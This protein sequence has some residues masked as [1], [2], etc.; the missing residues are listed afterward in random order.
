MAAPSTLVVTVRLAWWL[1]LYL[2]TLIA[3]C[4]L[5]GTEPNPDRLGYWVARGLRVRIR[6][7]VQRPKAR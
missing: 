7:V 2:A 1:R 4:R 6:P 3:L 5:L